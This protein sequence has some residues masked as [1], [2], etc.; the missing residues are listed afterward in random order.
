M[1]AIILS[2]LLLGGVLACTS[3]AIQHKNVLIVLSYDSQH[4]QYA[5]F[6][7]EVRETIELSGYVT[8]CKVLYMDLEYAPDAAFTSLHQMNDSL[9]K[10]GWIPNVIITYFS[11]ILLI[12]F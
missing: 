12:R 8:D 2:V 5:D 3:E 11:L 10:I 7:K 1:M 4:S 9:N 6:I